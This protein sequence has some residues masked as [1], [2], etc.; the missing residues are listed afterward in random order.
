M[1]AGPR[2][3][4]RAQQHRPRPRSLPARRAT[5]GRGPSDSDGCGTR[6]PRDREP[7]RATRARL[8]RRHRRP[9]AFTTALGWRPIWER[10]SHGWRVPPDRP[11][12]SCCCTGGRI[13][14][15]PG[16]WQFWLA[17]R[18]RSSGEQVLH[19]QLPRPD[20]PRLGE[21]IE[22]LEGELAQLGDGE[23]VVLCHS[24]ACLL[25]A[26]A[27][28]RLGAQARVDRLL[29]VAPPGPSR[30]LPQMSRFAPL[31]VD[32]RAIRTSAALRRLVCGD[33]DPH[34]PERADRL[35]GPLGLEG[36]L[37]LDAGFGPWPAVERWARGDVHARA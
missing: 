33:D 21:W 37:D 32:P 28:P 34:C 9:G 30:L 18:L 12:A 27:S 36:R 6:I 10:A 17:E 14:R 8:V 29:W 7:G 4:G 13:R 31:D 35:Y 23:R 20:E 3:E 5:R 25:W 2:P 24:L 15:P 22:L 19:P 1:R 26:P 11:G 16:H